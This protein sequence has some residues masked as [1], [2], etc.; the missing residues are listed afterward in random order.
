MAARPDEVARLLGVD[1]SVV[2]ELT[3]VGVTRDVEPLGA[4]DVR[5]LATALAFLDA[6]FTVQQLADAIERRTLSFEFA[7]TV[8]A[9]DG[10][11]STTVAELAARL[12]E[13]VETVR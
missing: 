3:S 9:P 12:G 2:T 10:P 1:V 6:G 8:P 4:G 11:G 13:P 7:E 5:R